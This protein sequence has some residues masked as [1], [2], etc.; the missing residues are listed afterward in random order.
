MKVV[1]VVNTIQRSWHIFDCEKN[2]RQVG[3]EYTIIEIFKLIIITSTKPLI[4]LATHPTTPTVKHFDFWKINYK[5]AK[6][7]NSIKKNYTIESM[8][9][10]IIIHAF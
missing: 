2:I 6:T 1:A 9:F 10:F 3:T 5:L 7:L 4:Y 8:K